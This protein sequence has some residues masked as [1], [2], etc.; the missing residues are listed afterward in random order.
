MS[1]SILQKSKNYTV[2]PETPLKVV[3]PAAVTA[4]SKLAVLVMGHRTSYAFNVS[5]LATETVAPVIYDDKFDAFSLIDSV[6]NLSQETGSSPPIV[7]PDASGNYPS[8]YA[9]FASATTGAQAVS[10]VD[11]GLAASSSPPVNSPPIALGRPVFDSGLEAVVFEIAGLSSGVTGHAH[12]TGDASALGYGIL[13][14]GS[15]SSL[16]L[17]LGMLIDSFSISPFPGSTS[18]PIPAAFLEYSSRFPAGSSSWVIQT[19]QQTAAEPNGGF[20]NPIEYVG[21][22]VALALK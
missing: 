20:A 10:I 22:V 8:I 18:P 5:S 16:V 3:L 14:P 9:F 19:T 6:V 11:A 13:T 12:A 21:G 4:G 1:I 7:S 17:E 2:Y 15:A